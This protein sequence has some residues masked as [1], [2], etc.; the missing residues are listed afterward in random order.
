M[1]IALLLTVGIVA[2]AYASLAVVI[3]VFLCI[4]AFY[5]HHVFKEFY[6]KIYLVFPLVFIMGYLIML[7]NC[8]ESSF[9]KLLENDSVECQIQGT[10]YKI[11]KS[12]TNTKY[13]LKDIKVTYNDKIM[14][15]ENAVIYSDSVFSKGDVIAAV[16]EAAL[17]D[18]P[19]NYGAFD[20]RL[21]YATINI[22]YRVY[23]KTAWLIAENTN[24]VYS[25]AEL[26]LDKAES[27]IY[28]ITET[29]YASV[30]GAMLLGNRDELDKDIGELFSACGI[31][32]ILAISGLHISLLGMGIY[33]L[34]RRSGVSYIPAMAVSVVLILFYG[35]ITGNGIS[36]VRALV[37]FIMVVYA[38]V[39]GRTYDMLSAAS[40]AAIL[41][42]INSP[43]L[44]YSCGF[45]LS[46]SA[47]LGICVVNPAISSKFSNDNKLVKI[48]AGGI[49]ISLMT[50]P[51][52]MFFYY[53]VPLLSILLN[54]AVVPLMT[55]VMLSAIAGTLLGL[56]SLTLGKFAIAS[57]V[58]LLKLFEVVCG[59][60]L[61]FP[62]AVIVTGK[63]QLWQLVLYYALL[64]LIV[65][66]LE[67]TDKKTV[68]VGLPV[69]FSIFCIR[70]NN[71]LFCC[72]IDVGQGDGLFIKSR[73]GTTYL[74]DCGSTDNDR[75]YEYT[76][77]PFLLS[78]G[79]SEIDNVIITHCDN[80][81]ISGIVDILTEGKISIGTIYMPST[82]L[83]DEAYMEFEELAA[84]SECEVKRIYKGMSIK[85]GGLIMDCL[86]PEY[87]FDTDDRN[88]YSAVLSVRYGDFKMLLT[89]DIASE[90]ELMV[91][92]ALRAAGMDGGYDILK[93]AHHGSKYSSCNEFLEYIMPE[94]GVISCSSKNMYG[95]PHEEAV[96]R[97]TDNDCGILCTKDIGAVTVKIDGDKVVVE[98]YL[99]K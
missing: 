75:L 77:E 41:M 83:I 71:D 63:P 57:G 22:K 27:I 54:A 52:I 18:K 65:Y 81:H 72:F 26:V 87:E 67:R 98:G 66:F 80:D 5:V 90:Q 61:K 99:E 48:F 91:L 20:L 74:I 88:N 44:I 76:V 96:S 24:P 29:R 73:T 69:I 40:L 1:A 14:N 2:G 25:L 53:E 49:S 62:W 43:M 59:S 37:M 3:I 70:F 97:L 60:N 15:T 68:L 82:L 21:Y 7:S 51:I 19:S 79:V 89:G 34:I 93:V 30:F 84:A 64:M 16:G 94:F 39:I 56:M 9:T 32:H 86:H 35:C 38:D 95:H 45:L 28:S 4:A 55:Y 6:S 10:V 58:Y 17:Y 47:V 42:L 8:K 33:K 36:T 78:K 85:D 11:K 31:G 12:D 50:T 13:F 46:Y 23:A 92:D